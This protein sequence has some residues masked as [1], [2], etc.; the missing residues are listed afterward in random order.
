LRMVYLRRNPNPCCRA[1]RAWKSRRS[2]SKSISYASSQYCTVFRQGLCY[3][4]MI[5]RIPILISR[6]LH[7]L[8][9]IHTS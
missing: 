6:R 1:R 8:L 2:S 7:S 3:F 4:M 5:G 9:I